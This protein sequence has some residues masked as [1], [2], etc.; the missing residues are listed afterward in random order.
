MLNSKSAAR[1]ESQVASEPADESDWSGV[2]LPFVLVAL[3]LLLAVVGLFVSGL[4]GPI[5]TSSVNVII[6]PQ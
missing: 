3:V 4:V 2:S 6:R 5:G 1:A